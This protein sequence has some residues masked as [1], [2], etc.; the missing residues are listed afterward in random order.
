MKQLKLRK[1]S[2]VLL[3]VSFLPSFA[4]CG[5]KYV[6]SDAEKTVGQYLIEHG[7]EDQTVDIS[8]YVSNYSEVGTSQLELEYSS[9]SGTYP[10]NFW[11]WFAHWWDDDAWASGLLAQ[12]GVAVTIDHSGE[13]SLRGYF[14]VLKRGSADV[15]Y[16]CKY[17][18][19]VS[20]HQFDRI[21]ASTMEIKTDILPAGSKKAKI[22]AFAI[23]ATGTAIAA[24]TNFLESH[25]LPYIY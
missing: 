14:S 5:S 12:L 13:T 4:G 3:F 24:A 22:Q 20:G 19:V 2:S 7:D 25:N 17:D 15:N 1:L 10:G 9:S 6:I 11:I 21:D 8:S 18:V 16:N 23:V